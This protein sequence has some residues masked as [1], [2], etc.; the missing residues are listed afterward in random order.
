MPQIHNPPV[1][2]DN[3]GNIKIIPKPFWRRCQFLNWAI[4]YRVGDRVNFD[5]EFEKPNTNKHGLNTHAISEFF[6]G[7]LNHNFPV[8]GLK[9][10]IHGN[11]INAEGDVVYSLGFMNYKDQQKHTIF[12][13]RA[14]NWDTILSRW[15]WAIIGAI[16]SYALGIASGLIEVKPFWKIWWPW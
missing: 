14:E 11:I 9:T 10:P 12:T 4:P 3:R 7:N 1:N 8:D 2:W 16:L 13:A 6:A 15:A 5:I